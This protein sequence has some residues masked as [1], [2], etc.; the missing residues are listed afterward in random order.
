[1]ISNA[2]VNRNSNY[3]FEVQEVINNFRFDNADTE[4]RLV[5][6][7]RVQYVL[8]YSY[9]TRTASSYRPHA[10]RTNLKQFTILYLVP[11]TWNSLQTHIT[12]SS[13]FLPVKKRM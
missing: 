2:K 8:S 12:G 3:V 7:S 5:N 11:N 9:D 1:M 13:S 10:C 4:K 6:Y